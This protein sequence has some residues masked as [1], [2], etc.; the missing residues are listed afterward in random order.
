MY[1]SVCVPSASIP[2]CA[3]A[4]VCVRVC[5]RAYVPCALLPAYM[6]TYPK[7]IKILETSAE[8]GGARS[9]LG[10][11]VDLGA[12]DCEGGD[13]GEGGL[14]GRGRGLAGMEAGAARGG[15]GF[16]GAG[17]FRAPVGLRVRVHGMIFWGNVAGI[18]LIEFVAGHVSRW[19]SA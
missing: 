3:Y 16:N 6:Y 17:E 2:T 5:A 7:H 15:G 19:L 10:E 11:T 9:L 14:E 1:P 8:A 4:C 13:D 18:L 12:E